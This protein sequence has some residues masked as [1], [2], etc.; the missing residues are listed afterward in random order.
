M[1]FLSP[2]SF[3]VVGCKCLLVLSFFGG[4]QSILLGQSTC[5]YF[6]FCFKD[7]KTQLAIPA[8]VSEL[9]I[10]DGFSNGNLVTFAFRA[11]Q[12]GTPSQSQNSHSTVP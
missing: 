11:F 1:A 8:S 7:T 2:K 3:K 9:F 4:S 5:K 10:L 12:N 6:F